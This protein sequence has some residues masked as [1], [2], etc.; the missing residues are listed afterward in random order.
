MLSPYR[1]ILT[2]PGALAFSASGVLAR[3]P[4]SMVG[5]G[6]VLMVSSLYGSYGLAGAVSA[7]YVVSQA[8]C[9][10]QLAR[11]IDRH[12]QARI[13]SPAVAT[14]AF[15]LVGLIVAALLEAPSAFLFVGAVITGAAIGSFGSLV[16]ARWTALLGEDP[17]RT[18]TA[19]SLES[20]LDELVFVVGPVLATVLA[21][22]VA[23]T[24]GLVVP[25][26]A[27]IAGGYWFLSLRS[28]EPPSAPVGSPR[29]RGS[30][31]ANPGMAVLAI[32]F[33]AMGTIFGATDVSTVAYADESGSKGLAGVILAVFALGSLIS[34]LLYGTRQWKRPLY[35]RF[36]NGM[37]LL[38][39]GVCAFFFVQSLVALA[40]VMF[41]VGFTIAPTLINGNGL[42]QE[43]V[44]RARLTEGLTW[45][46]TSLGVG[47]SIGSSI[48]GARIDAAGS[49]AGFLVV[50]VAAVLAVIATLAALRT[51]RGDASEHV[52][53]AVEPGS[54]SSTGGAAVAACEIA[55]SVDP[56]KPRSR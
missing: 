49:H 12:G 40:A 33:V 34:G 36:A 9:S 26:V 21:T 31:L 30:V 10:P 43:L 50:V 17:H 4:M 54:P 29:P 51:L 32:V 6:I 44:P 23:P 7:V 38:A 52:H 20:A 22:G 18:H 14:A 19:Y 27:M 35:L 13:M 3:L 39:V 11:L 2:R 24:A 47:V 25:L 53:D 1:D 16:R 42:V 46:G 5:I 37:V 48:A 55:E 15:G 28:T 41:V 56:S 8:V 45:V